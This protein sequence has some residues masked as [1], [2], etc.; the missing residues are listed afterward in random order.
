MSDV[1][2]A[3]GSIS[4]KVSSKGVHG[5]CGLDDL[6]HKEHPMEWLLRPALTLEHYVAVPIDDPN[7]IEYEPF[8]SKR[9]LRDVRGEG[10]T[11]RYASMSCCEVDCA[12]SYRM[13]PPHYVDIVVTAQTA[14]AQWPHNYLALFFATIVDTPIYTGVNVIGSDPNVEFNRLNPWVH[15]NGQGETPGRT[16]H[17]SGVANPELARPDDPPNIYYFDDSSVRFD[18]PFF[19]GTVDHMVFGAFF[20]NSDREKVRFTVN[21]VAS[22]FGGPAWDFFWL[23]EDPAPREIRQLPVRV[24]W[25]PFISR[26]D[27]LD[28]YESYN[29]I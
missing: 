28:E 6:T 15:F 22:G 2:I 14:R 29:V 21:P 4:A 24:I 19:Y 1:R 7:Y 27:I 11:L 8:G 20:K 10:C 12:I 9:T 3:A 16:I 18:L 5:W 13:T 26:Q 23:L 17:P 25:K